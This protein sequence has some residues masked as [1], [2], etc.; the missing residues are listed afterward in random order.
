MKYYKE[1]GF[2]YANAKNIEGPSS[3]GGNKTLRFYIN[4]NQVL[5]FKII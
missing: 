4:N 3:G 5:K 2:S 1:E